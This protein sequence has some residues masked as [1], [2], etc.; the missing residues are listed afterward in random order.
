MENSRKVRNIVLIVI[1]VVLAVLAVLYFLT[2]IFKSGLSRDDVQ[3]ILDKR[4]SLISVHARAYMLPENTMNSSSPTAYVEFFMNDNFAQVA[5]VLQ[6]GQKIIYQEDKATGD[7]TFIDEPLKSILLKVDAVSAFSFKPLK[8]LSDISKYKKF[9]YLGTT[10]INERKT[11]IIFLQ[12]NEDS[13]KEL[14][15]IDD[16]TG[17]VV[18]H[19]RD[20][21]DSY[22]TEFVHI[23]PLN[24]TDFM[25]DVEKV[26]PDYKMF[27]ISQRI[28]K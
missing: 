26:Y 11:I 10:M 3:A 28:E 14:V 19:S 12:E 6:N 20:Y 24:S 13:C 5:Y 9:R 7:V 15:Y 17:L 8:E 27:D 16:E 4:N 23:E 18:E 25:I 21:C 1:L 2:P 22:F